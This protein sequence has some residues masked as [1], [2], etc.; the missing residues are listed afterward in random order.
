MIQC[1]YEEIGNKESARETSETIQQLAQHINLGEKRYLNQSLISISMGL[2][3]VRPNINTSSVMV[4]LQ[5]PPNMNTSSVMVNMNN[6]NLNVNQ[7]SVNVNMNNPINVNQ[8]SV[9]VNVNNPVNVNQS[10]VNVDLGPQAINQNWLKPANK[11]SVN[12]SSVDIKL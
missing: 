3:G 9:N 7:S 1:V 4:N 5:S 10:S 11:A 8:S 2:G 6:P 12:S